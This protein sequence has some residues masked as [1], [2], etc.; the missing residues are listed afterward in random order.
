[1]PYR[2]PDYAPSTVGTTSR[3]DD[4]D[5][6]DSSDVFS[7]KDIFPRPVAATPLN[8]TPQKRATQRPSRKSLTAESPTS[9]TIFPGIEEY[10]PTYGLRPEGVPTHS[11]YEAFGRLWEKAREGEGKGFG[12]LMS[13]TGQSQSVDD[14]GD[15]S[16]VDWDEE[17]EELQSFDLVEVDAALQSVAQDDLRRSS[18]RRS[19]VTSTDEV[20]WETFPA[21]GG[22]VITRPRV[23]HSQSQIRA[24][25]E[26]GG[27]AIQS[28]GGTGGSVTARASSIGGA[29]STIGVSL[30]PLSS[31]SN[32]HACCRAPDI[33]PHPHRSQRIHRNSDSAHLPSAD[34]PPLDPTSSHR[35]LRATLSWLPLPPRLRR[36]TDLDRHPPPPH[37]PPE[38]QAQV[39]IRETVLVPLLW[40]LRSSHLKSQLRVCHCRQTSPL[41]STVSSAQLPSPAH[42]REDHSPNATPDQVGSPYL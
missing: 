29:S 22:G 32:A 7:Q 35:Q 23:Y 2:D 14:R 19:T 34:S 9:Y 1:M 24:P 18:D 30:F 8:I 28:P 3:A 4:S 31:I 27:L 17:Q 11:G 20:E 26:V 33:E 37:P 5:D 12:G 41:S 39:G 10:D 16:D 21:V 38:H 42:L 6:E 25:S 36:L 40:R 13:A 15:V